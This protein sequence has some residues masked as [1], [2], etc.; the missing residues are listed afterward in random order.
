MNDKTDY[1]YDVF[2]SYSHRNKE[3]VRGILLPRLENAGVKV[4]ID[5]RDFIIGAP[6][7]REME[8][9]IMMS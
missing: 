9:G 7:V 6:L 3:W 2:I 4:F 8:R 1:Q 5:F